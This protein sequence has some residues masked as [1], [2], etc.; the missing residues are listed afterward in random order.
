[1]ASIYE[2]HFTLGGGG[3]GPVPPEPCPCPPSPDVVLLNPAAAPAVPLLNA[4]VGPG[5]LC[6]VWAVDLRDGSQ[7]PPLLWL[8]VFDSLA[9]PTS[10]V[11]QPTVSAL[12]LC[13]TASYVWGTDIFTITNGVWVALSSTPLVYT[14]VAAS[15]EFTLTARVTP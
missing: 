14:A 15:Q 1:M 4:L 5:Q 11:T 6:E 10:G 7:S 12:P 13:C 2:T 3:G 9:A 8:Q